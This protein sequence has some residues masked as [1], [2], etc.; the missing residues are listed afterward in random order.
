MSLNTLWGQN[1][2][3]SRCLGSA[4]DKGYRVDWAED[5]REVERILHPY[6]PLCLLSVN[7]NE[8]K[9]GERSRGG[10]GG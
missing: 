1:P 10:L 3:V 4:N 5:E 7:K 8:K 6:Y 9:G 2:E